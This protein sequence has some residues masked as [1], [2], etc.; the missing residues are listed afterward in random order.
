M[1]RGWVY[2]ED[3][4]PS[5]WFTRKSE[6]DYARFDGFQR[7]ITV[8]QRPLS[9]AQSEGK[10]GP[11][12]QDHVRTLEAFHSRF[13]NALVRSRADL[14]LVDNVEV[15]DRRDHHQDLGSITRYCNGARR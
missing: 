7:Y 3:R 8:A 6:K 12:Q 14:A 15:R 2:Q 4:V 9:C 1:T 11:E 13:G 10:R 5:K